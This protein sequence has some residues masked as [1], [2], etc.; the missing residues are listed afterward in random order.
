MNDKQTERDRRAGDAGN[1][2]VAAGRRPYTK[3]TLTEYGSI[4]KLTQGTRTNQ[5]DAG[6]GGGFKMTCL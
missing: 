3:P 1:P 5:S 2:G 6:G 4:A